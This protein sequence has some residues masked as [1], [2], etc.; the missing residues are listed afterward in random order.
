MKTN[1]QILTTTLILL[2]TGFTNIAQVWPKYYGFSN[3][4]DYADDI[5]ESYDKGYL[6]CGNIYN[7]GTNTTQSSWLIKTDINGDTLWE[8]IITNEQQFLRSLT[9][10]QAK[11]GGLLLA[12]LSVI[13]ENQSLPYIMKLN[14]CGEKEWCKLFANVEGELPWVQAVKETS[15]GN[16]VLLVNQYGEIPEETM[17]L[18]KLNA[19]GEVL[20]KKSY[21]SGYVYPESAHPLGESVFITSE[22]KY[23]ISGNVYWENPWNPGGIKIIRP[24]FVMVDSIG[25]EEW[26]LPF[27]LQDTIYGDAFEVIELENGNFIGAGSQWP[28]SGKDG[29]FIAFNNNGNTFDYNILDLTIVDPI[30]EDGIFI[31][32]K[33]NDTVFITGCGLGDLN[34]SLKGG[35]LVFGNNIFEPDFTVFYHRYDQEAGAPYTMDKTTFNKILSNS[36]KQES[37]NWDIKLAKLNMQLEYD[38]LIPVPYTYDSLCTTPGLPQS[39]FISL[40]TCDIITGFDI[41]S[42]EE[43]YANLQKIPVKVYPNP[44]MKGQITFE[45]KNTKHHSNIELKCFGIYGEEVHKE[46]V[47][48]HQGKSIVDISRW[49]KGMYIVVVYSGGLPVGRCKFVINH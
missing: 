7:I 18:F 29:L 32:L 23:L 44:A 9:I 13:E 46:K 5:S 21:C 4:Y 41:P 45:F 42:P 14:A 16:I 48:R 24:L 37:G 40:D 3:S 47:Y 34:Q 10:E 31:N 43:Y 25:S 39:G 30:Y 6:I 35:E 11:D 49:Q 19:F 26:I 2:T 38:S 33:R 36:T 15:S 27:G 8:K 22:N 20:W 28:D 12:G 1:I 17:H